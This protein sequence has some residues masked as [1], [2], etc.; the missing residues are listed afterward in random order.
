M[1]FFSGTVGMRTS[2]YEALGAGSLGRWVAWWGSFQVW[3][4][5]GMMTWWYEAF[6]LLKVPI[7]GK[8]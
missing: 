3:E 4:L 8:V 2:W 7:P 5:L 1:L 6:R